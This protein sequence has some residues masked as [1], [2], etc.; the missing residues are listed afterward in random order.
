MSARPA[1]PDSIKRA[2]KTALVEALHENREF[3][4]EGLGRL[5][6]EGDRERVLAALDPPPAR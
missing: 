6:F 4:R 2:V 5:P 1:N 3:L